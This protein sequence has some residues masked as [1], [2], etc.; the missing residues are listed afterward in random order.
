MKARFITPPPTISGKVITPAG[1]AIVR[2][3]VDSTTGR[4]ISIPYAE[5]AQVWASTAST[6]KVNAAPDGSYTL[7]VTNPGTFTLTASYPTSRN[8][9]TSTPQTVNTTAS[10]HTQNIA[11]NYAY[12]TTISGKVGLKIVRPSWKVSNHGKPRG[13][14][15][16]HDGL[17]RL[18]C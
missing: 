18:H 12:R 15:F 11:L 7:S 10:T 8:Y 13:I 16:T 1:K 14:D 4:V 6:T 5:D 3:N 17:R 9:K 2:Y